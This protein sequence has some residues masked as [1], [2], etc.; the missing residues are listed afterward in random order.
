MDY[1]DVQLDTI[2][3]PKDQVHYLTREI[4]WAMERVHY[5]YDLETCIDYIMI[6]SE[7]VKGILMDQRVEGLKLGE[8]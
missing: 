1:I 7:K 4:R 8:K 6:C 5:G 2:E 3:D